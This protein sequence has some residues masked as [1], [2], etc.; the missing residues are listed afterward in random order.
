MTETS[1][2]T[3]AAEPPRE[4]PRLVSKDGQIVDTTTD[5]WVLRTS[6]DGG[7]ILRFNWKA[8]RSAK[9]QAALDARSTR[10]LQLFAA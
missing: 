3:S 4:R 1:P 5:V 8:F 6:P 2:T 9:G 7:S 10:I